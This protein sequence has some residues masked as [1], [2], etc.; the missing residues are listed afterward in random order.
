MMLNFC[1]DNVSITNEIQFERFQKN[2]ETY[3]R[4]KTYKLNTYS[5]KI[6]PQFDNIIDPNSAL[7]IL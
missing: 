2:G 3:M 1:L 7:G 5:Q 4:I 6:T